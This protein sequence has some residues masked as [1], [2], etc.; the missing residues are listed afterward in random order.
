MKLRG[1]RI[2]LG[3]IEAAL[4]DVPG[5]RQ[6]VVIV[7]EFGHGDDRLVGYVTLRPDA[8]FD[9]EAARA[10]LRSRLPEYM[11][12]NLFAVLPAMPLTPNGKLDRKALP[13]P[14]AGEEQHRAPL[15]TLMTGEQRRVAAIWRDVLRSERIGLYENFF[16][17][18]GHS[19]LLVRLHAELK[20]EFENDF[21]LVELFQHTTVAAQADRMSSPRNLRDALLPHAR[22]RFERADA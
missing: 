1:H 11:V 5:V 16:D 18:G 12:P 21:P 9:I 10:A 2:E 19:L 3:E 22:V 7:R 4:A 14:Q 13:A 8:Q 6:S 20:R 15:E 17:I